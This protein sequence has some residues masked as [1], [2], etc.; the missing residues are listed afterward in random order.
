MGQ[1]STYTRLSAARVTQRDDFGDVVPALRHVCRVV[2][3]KE[4]DLTEKQQ[5]SNVGP[6]QEAATDIWVVP[7]AA[8][9]ADLEKDALCVSPSSSSFKND[10]FL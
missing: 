7:A 10:L 9:S 3:W 6:N 2:C 8:G 1:S 4:S 5:Q